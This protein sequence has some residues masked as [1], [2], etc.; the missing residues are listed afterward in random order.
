MAVPARSA[1]HRHFAFLAAA[2]FIAA[3]DVRSPTNPNVELEEQPGTP[4]IGAESI[5]SGA[6][7][8]WSPDGDELYFE[9]A[10]GSVRA[11]TIGIPGSRT[12]DSPRER[13]ELTTAHS[14]GAVY[15]VA[16]RTSQG[17]TV[18]RVEG[19]AAEVLTDRAPPTSVLGQADG[20]LVLGGPED[21]IAAYIVAPDSLFIADL[22]TEART[23]IVD[24]CERVVAFAPDSDRLI[25]RTEGPRASGYAEVDIAQRSLMPRQLLAGNT[26][27]RIVRWDEQ[28]LRVLFTA[29]NRFQVFD[30]VSG[31]ASPLWVPPTG[32]G[33]RVL[34]FLHY[35]W[36]GDGSRIAYWVHECLILDRVG[37]CEFGQSILYL[38]ELATN[39]G[40]VAAVVHGERGAEQIVLDRSGRAAAWVFDGRLYHRIIP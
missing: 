1:R 13:G 10:D 18:F 5:P 19:G 7:L 26:T 8:L 39:T 24:G 27:I 29:A 33:P 21:R 15:F 14:G 36:S 35:A 40:K 9:A 6:T 16:N 30:V 17:A 4:V 32:S 25:C 22:A 12:L 20:R 38:V 31:S 34:D 3:C 37:Q 28:G 23:F 2:S 11:V